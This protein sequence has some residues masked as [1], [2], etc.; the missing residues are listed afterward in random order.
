[1]GRWCSGVRLCKVFRKTHT[2]IPDHSKVPEGF[3]KHSSRREMKGTPLYL[4]RANV[5]MKS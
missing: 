1:M 4:F 3:E 2:Y 5:F